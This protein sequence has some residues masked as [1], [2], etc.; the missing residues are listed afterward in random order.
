MHR[1]DCGN[2]GEA[3]C[4]SESHEPGSERPRL[5]KIAR[6]QR[7]R[8]E[9]YVLSLLG[10]A[11]ALAGSERHHV[12]L[13]DA[14][15]ARDGGLAESSTRQAL[16]WAMTQTGRLLDEERAKEWDWLLRA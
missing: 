7:L 15:R 11:N 8:S 4:R 16:A 14:C 5:L 10:S 2:A 6:H 9:R 13:V 3:P 12:N 1:R